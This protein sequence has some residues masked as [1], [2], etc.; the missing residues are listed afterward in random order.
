V[1]L[2]GMVLRD[3][4]VAR[5]GGRVLVIDGEAWFERPLART[6]V[7]VH[8]P[9]PP[10]QGP[11]ALRAHG[12]DVNRLDRV[13][14]HSG[15]VLEGWATLTGT[16][17]GR[18]LHVHEQAP[19]AA[20]RPPKSWTTPPCPPPPTGWPTG[21]VYH[22]MTSANL[23]QPAPGPDEQAELTITQL[24]IF[25]P[26]ETQ[27]VLVAAAED[28]ERAERALRPTFGDALCV[29]ASRYT[30]Q[31]IDE[32]LHRLRTE[33]STHRW[34][35]TSNGRS[36]DRDGQATVFARFAWIEPEV[37]EWAATVPDGLLD[38]DIWLTPVDQERWVPSW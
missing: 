21:P 10:H 15:G 38:L 32:T 4:V 33:M 27:P 5:A 18:E 23:P 2:T 26:Q 6:L 13:E 20:W 3:G 29:I 9:R 1:D 12:V 22:G 24:T 35:M 19:P 28:P 17:R 34:P 31:E 37:A 14:R 16:V 36:A 7:K 25:H 11:H 8:P 30:R